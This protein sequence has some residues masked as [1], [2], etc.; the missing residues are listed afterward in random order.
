MEDTFLEAESGLRQEQVQVFGARLTGAGFDGACVALV[1]E[2]TAAAVASRV[3]ELYREKGEQGKL[4][5]PR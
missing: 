5:V 2:G 4:L 1:R 3:L